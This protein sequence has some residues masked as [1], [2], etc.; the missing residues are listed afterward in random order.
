M[1][2][3]AS[4]LV[5]AEILTL[6]ALLPRWFARDPLDV[7]LR[8]LSLP[9]L[10]GA[11]ADLRRLART[12]ARAEGLVERTTPLPTTCLYRALA[13][14]AALRSA[15]HE[16]T[17]VMGLPRSGAGAAGH[18][19]VEVDGAAF[20]EFDDVSRFKVTFRYPPVRNGEMVASR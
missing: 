16:P 1:R 5:T 18:A 8:R 2:V 11:R 15:G 7:L 13:R 19:W 10:P 3:L 17:F 9:R 6:R 14:Y 20:A 4:A 12:V